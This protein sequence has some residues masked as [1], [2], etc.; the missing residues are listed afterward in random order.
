MSFPTYHISQ[1]NTLFQI[2]RMEDLYEQHKGAPDDP[3]RHNYYTVIW[4]QEGQGKHRVDFEEYPLQKNAVFFVSP[5]QVH[6]LISTGKPKGIVINFSKEFLQQ[7]HISEDFI[8]GINLFNSFEKRPPVLLSEE[9]SES[10]GKVCDL[11]ISASEHPMRNQIAALSAG[12][13]LFLVLCEN[14]CDLPGPH[15]ESS[16]GTRQ[17]LKTFKQLVEQDFSKYHMVSDYAKRMHI[18]SR[19]LNQVVK[20]LIGQTAKS[21][22]QEKITLNA[23]R[24]LRFSDKSI[25]EIAFELGFDDPLYFSSF[26][27]KCTGMTPSEFRSSPK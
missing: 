11:M 19:Y 9:A 16:Q 26:F 5:G 4:A 18:S 10:L 27:K 3:H 6:Q 24:E 17:L 22:I 2:K 1:G 15:E 23:R 14:A 12:L 20:D 8:A 21:L 25:K 7:N 13:K